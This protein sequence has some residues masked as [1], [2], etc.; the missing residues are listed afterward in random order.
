MLM[1][2][3]HAIAESRAENCAYD[4]ADADSDISK[5]G[6]AAAEVVAGLEDAGNGAEKNINIGK[7][8]GENAAQKVALD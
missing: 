5:A 3:S 6:N 4:V 8:D 7:R 2:A 1:A